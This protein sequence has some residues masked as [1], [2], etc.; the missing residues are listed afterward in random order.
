M[1]QANMQDMVNLSVEFSEAVQIAHPAAMG[2]VNI[3]DV[4]KVI[5]LG[6]EV[7]SQAGMPITDD[8]MGKA[9]TF[10]EMH[11]DLFTR[12]VPKEEVAKQVPAGLKKPENI[13]MLRQ[14][15]ATNLAALCTLKP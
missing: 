15:G 1:T 5:K 10:A 12:F 13:E 4:K 6:A 9:I 8:L 3:A 7:L 14:A 11:A 2:L